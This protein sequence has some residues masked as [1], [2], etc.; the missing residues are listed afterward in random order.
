MASRRAFVIG[1][2]ALAT[3][4]AAPLSVALAGT[5]L[6]RPSRTFRA[7]ALLVVMDHGL[8]QA[9][10]FAADAEASGYRALGFVSDVAASWMNEIEPRLRAGPVA[11]AGLTS[12]ATLFCIELL[13]RDYGAHP[14]RRIEHPRG[15][16]PRF[17]PLLAAGPPRASLPPFVQVAAPRAGAAPAVFSWLIA[18]DAR[19]RSPLARVTAGDGHGE[20]LAAAGA[21]N[22]L[23][24]RD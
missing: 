10:A 19:R 12:A 2:A 24:A 17:E 8:A 5:R 9:A 13:A 23:E 20:F 18:T 21:E 14:L 1:G 11:I 4:A 22:H 7:D 15:S 16:V 3:L 6:A